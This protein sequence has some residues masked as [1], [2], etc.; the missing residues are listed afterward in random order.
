MKLV[1]DVRLAGWAGILTFFTIVIPVFITG[2]FPKF[3]PNFR[4][5]NADM[6]AF[7]ANDSMAIQLQA[8]LAMTL[9]L[10]IWWAAGLRELLYVPGQTSILVR[11]VGWCQ[12]AFVTL[13]FLSYAFWVAPAIRAALNPNPINVE[14]TSAFLYGSAIVYFD[15]FPVMAL[16][17]LGT[18][19]A[20]LRT[21]VFPRWL[22]ISALV[23]AVPTALWSQ[24]ALPTLLPTGSAEPFSLLN[25]APFVLYLLWVPLTGYFMARWKPP[26][27]PT[28]TQTPQA[29]HLGST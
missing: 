4:D 10:Y 16:T 12:A 6:F 14:I 19:L 18:G 1:R 11:M 17:L 9:P 27:P 7:V 20:I 23:L 22:G 25:M 2:H 24:T 29:L 13:A 28:T 15:L 5:S 3:Y 26:Q 21:K 8:L